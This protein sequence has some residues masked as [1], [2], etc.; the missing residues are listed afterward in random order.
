MQEST[1][2]E[3]VLKGHGNLKKDI[4]E[5]I[6]EYIY[7]GKMDVQSKDTDTIME[8]LGEAHYFSMSELVDEI[9]AY[10]KEANQDNLIKWSFKMLLFAETHSNH[11]LKEECFKELEVY[12]DKA[13]LD[14]DLGRLSA[15]TLEE[16]ISR[17]SFSALEEN[18]FHA[19]IRWIM[20]FKPGVAQPLEDGP[21][22]EV[23]SLLAAVRLSQFNESFLEAQW[24]RKYFS[25]DKILDALV[26]RKSNCFLKR[27][28][29]GVPRTVPRKSI[30]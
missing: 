29:R 23:K 9:L 7:S 15:K 4:F 25:A 24:L 12:P 10:L 8:I 28:D 11:N 13:I 30:L 14:E 6:L 1:K 21:C 26:L 3:I 5:P 19:V 17:D 16:L 2:D 20:T 18:I 27:K 22:P